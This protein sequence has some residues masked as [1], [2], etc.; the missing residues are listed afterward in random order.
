[1]RGGIELGLRLGEPSSDHEEPFALELGALIV[2]IGVA[3]S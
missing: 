3:T 2:V 1:L